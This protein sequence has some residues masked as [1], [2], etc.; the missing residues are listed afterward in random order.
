MYQEENK[1]PSFF[2]FEDLRVYDKA[3]NFA[4]WLTNLSRRAR[5]DNPIE[6]KFYKNIVN[7]A[8]LTALNIADGSAKNKP[9]F[10]EQLKESKSNIRRVLVLSTIG[11]NTNILSEEEVDEIRNQMMEMTKM[12]GA[13]I[14]SLQ[15]NNTYNHE[16]QVD[17]NF[18]EPENN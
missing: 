2:R 4:T 18:F 12:L 3:V 7:E 11:K 5:N 8:T 16:Q 10:A 14:S 15:K 1:M 13:L 17:E 6:K 9:A